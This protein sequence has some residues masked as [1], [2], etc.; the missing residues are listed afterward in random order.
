MQAVQLTAHCA[1]YRADVNPLIRALILDTFKINS[2][3]PCSHASHY[4]FTS[5]N[6]VTSSKNATRYRKLRAERPGS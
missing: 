3:F 2:D 4:H 1:L 5:R 6:C